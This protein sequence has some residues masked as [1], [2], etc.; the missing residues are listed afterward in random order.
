[1]TESSVEINRR[2]AD[3]VITETVHAWHYREQGPGEPGGRT[4]GV[5]YAPN[6][7]VRIDVSDQSGSAYRTLWLAASEVRPQQEWRDHLLTTGQ[8][9][10]IRRWCTV[11]GVEIPE[12]SN[13]EWDENCCSIDCR[14][15]LRPNW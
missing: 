1:M 10:V 2:L 9:P 4:Y 14:N 8:K 12:D 15:D 6:G 7:R 5:I 13:P 3:G 11:D